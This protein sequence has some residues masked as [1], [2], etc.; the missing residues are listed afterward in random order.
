MKF[1]SEEWLKLRDDKL[2]EWL[3]DPS[4]V[5]LAQIIGQSTEL[6]DDMLDRDVDIGQEKIFHLMH[7][8]WVILPFNEFWNRHKHFLM[9][10]LMMSLNAWLDSNKLEGGD[11]ADTVYAYTMRNLTLQVLPMMV[12]IIHGEKRMREVSLEIHK[13]FTDHESYEEYLRKTK[14]GDG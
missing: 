12:Y 6:F 7:S 14:D 2:T 4:A 5:Q 10:I 8:L 9:P 11:A 1:D 3:G 13:F